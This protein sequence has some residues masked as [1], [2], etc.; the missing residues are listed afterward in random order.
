M[1]LG[2]FSPSKKRPGKN[3]VP[4]VLETLKQAAHLLILMFVYLRRNNVVAILGLVHLNH[5]KTENQKPRFD[6][7]LKGKSNPLL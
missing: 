4:K 6:K 7:S 3:L 5:G 2:L 1:W